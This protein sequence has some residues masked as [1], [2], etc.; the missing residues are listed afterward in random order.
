MIKYIRYLPKIKILNKILAFLIIY[1]LIDY[2]IGGMIQYLFSKQ[3]SGALYRTSY[4]MGKTTADIL[5]FGASKANHSYN[6]EVFRKLMPD[7]T[8]YNSG[9]DGSSIFYHYTILK[10][11]LKRYS[12]K[13][14]ILDFVP[15]EF[16]L[17][18]GHYEK[19]SYL[20]PFVNDHR[21]VRP[22]ISLKSPYE[23][24][25]LLSKI[26]PYNSLL[27]SIVGGVLN[28]HSTDD[29]EDD[30]YVALE[31]E[32]ES[33]IKIDSL[34]YEYPLDKNKIDYFEEF[35]DDCL[36]AKVKLI[37][38][39][40]PSFVIKSQPDYSVSIGKEIAENKN[41]KFY[42]YTN[43]KNFINYPKLFRDIAHLNNNGAKK[44]TKILITDIF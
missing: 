26:Y 38:S 17:V 13:I 28:I 6:T 25:K 11:V 42:D 23:R 30:G 29:V 9:N 4:S 1:I 24:I 2:S 19:L 12:P 16:R 27:L 33:A 36:E 5:I 21:E 3:K 35:I 8:S 22:M 18:P 40:A 15:G 32:W 20:L 39:C 44:F 43:D 34:G 31:G 41:I 14:I 10:T 7:F 37:I